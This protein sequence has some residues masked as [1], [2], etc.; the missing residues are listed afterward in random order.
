M[1]RAALY[2]RVSTQEQ[3]LYGISI[4]N[5]ADA[6]KKFCEE[7]NYAVVDVYNDAGI[8]ARK[9]Y[10]KRPELLRLMDDC[11]TGKI[12]IILFT[13][14]DRWF[15]S[16]SDYYKVQNVLDECKVPWRAI[17]EDYETETSSGVFKVNIMLSIAQAEAD[18]TREKVKSVMDYK[19]ES[20][21][22]IGRPPIGYIVK[23][24]KLVKDESRAEA[25]N[26]FYQTYLRTYSPQESIDA[27]SSY[28][29]TIAY[30]TATK[31]LRKKVYAGV[32]NEYLDCEPYIT[33]DEFNT[34]QRH[35]DSTPRKT[36]FGKAYIFAGLVRCHC[37]ARMS[38]TSTIDHRKR[39][40]DLEKNFYKCLNLEIWMLST[41]IRQAFMSRDSKDICSAT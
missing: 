14:L 40:G 21:E 12:D 20:G 32:V 15:R 25:I 38:G 30:V 10:D 4:D 3:K 24:K 17:W 5:Q 33:M 19:K 7:N 11:K 16:V 27:A 18:R 28:G 23:D 37:G 6:L 13:R 29:T 26:A 41:G 34:I 2:V 31:M 8:S 39:K 36:K 35:L 9:S 1:K 22:Y